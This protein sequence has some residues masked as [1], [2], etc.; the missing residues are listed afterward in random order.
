MGKEHKITD[1]CNQGFS[2]GEYLTSGPLLA[3][4][5]LTVECA[6]M[7]LLK[8]WQ[9]VM[10]RITNPPNAISLVV[11]LTCSALSVAQSLNAAHRLS[12]TLLS[13]NIES[14]QIVEGSKVTL[15]YQVAVPDQNGIEYDDVSEFVQG[16]HEIFQA[17]EREVA[18]MRPGEEKKVELTAEE[19]FG[20]RDERKKMKIPRTDLPADAKTG[21]VVQNEAGS[22][23][24]VAA[25]SGSTAVL[26]YNH[27]LAGKPLVVQL[28]IVKVE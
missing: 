27:P 20:S 19:G 3:L 22:F 2:T 9:G 11:I 14:P 21:D 12:A 10:M 7:K 1:S 28:R 16:R 15:Q 5:N 26:D 24:T 8:I 13:P 23:A 25:V 6:P 17:L 18:G 4:L